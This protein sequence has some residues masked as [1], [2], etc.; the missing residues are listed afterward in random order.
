MWMLLVHCLL[1]SFATRREHAKWF[2]QAASEDELISWVNA[3]E[4]AS[5]HSDD[6]EQQQEAGCN[7]S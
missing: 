4:I 5:F 3:I 6:A 2:L 7:I 1:L